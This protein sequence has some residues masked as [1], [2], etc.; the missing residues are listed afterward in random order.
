MKMMTHPACR[1]VAALAVLLGVCKASTASAQDIAEHLTLPDRFT[2]EIFARVPGARTLTL[3]PQLGVL[4]VSSRDHQIFAVPLNDDDGVRPAYP[5]LSRL[6]VPNGIAWRDGYL[7]VAEQHRLTRYHVP[8]LDALAGA[9]PEM[10]FDALPD[11][12][13]HG[14]RYIAFA[15]ADIPGGE[16]LYVG[17]GAPCNICTT[18]GYE[19]AILRFTPGQ[20]SSPDIVARG[21]RNTVGFDAHPTTGTLHFTDNGAD[22]M[23][24][25]SP[26][27]ELNALVPGA[28][29]GFPWFGG[30]R[31]RTR[32]MADTQP[33]TSRFPVH[34]FQA[35]V[36]PLGVDFYTGTQFPADYVNDA[37]VAQHG[38][39][40]RSSPVGYRVMRIR[41]DA[42]G[43]VIDAVPFITGW[44][45]D[46]ETKLGRP[47]DIEEMPDGALLISDDRAGVIYR[48]QYAAP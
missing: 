11:N 25:D 47:V 39:W 24:D 32:E 41:F 15:P 23:G 48:V 40:N 4:F 42:D 12:P 27:D 21:V 14:W 3:A 35:H 16:A 45:K 13:W 34:A 30:G 7:Y 36:A 29:Y 20:W 5:V 6:K 31:D 8:R 22:G 46:A 38:S 37:F 10:L 17:V 1:I 19:G 44:L 18:K 26:P 28:H 33:P 9:E 2:I 43:R